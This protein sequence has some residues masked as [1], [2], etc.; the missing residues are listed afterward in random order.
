MADTTFQNGALEGRD[1]P[2][3][4][5]IK[6]RPIDPNHTNILMIGFGL[7]WLALTTAWITLNLIGTIQSSLF[8][9][10]SYLILPIIPV[11]FIVVLC[12]I[13]TNRCGYALREHDVHYKHGIV[14]RNEASLPFNRIQHVEVE[15]GPL[16]RLFGLST[17]KFFAAGG[18]SA[19]LR[20]P[21]LPEAE[22]A[23]LRAFVLEKAGADHDDA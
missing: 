7:S 19:D 16:E 23:K 12:H 10:Y 9:G 18:G 14:W 4:G 15:R 11:P 2:E 22:A 6:F 8:T 13:Y 17:L 5:E 3:A 1:L 20:I 21:S